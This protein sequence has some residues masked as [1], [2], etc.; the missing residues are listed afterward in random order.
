MGTCLH[1]CTHF[2]V[3]SCVHV[4]LSMCSST[5]SKEACYSDLWLMSSVGQQVCMCVSVHVYVCMSERG[6]SGLRFR[7]GS[8]CQ[9]QEMDLS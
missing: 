1:L 7:G 9:G 8:W 4:L 3:S 2:C 6:W 5:G